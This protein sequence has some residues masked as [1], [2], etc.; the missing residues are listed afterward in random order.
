MKDFK[1]VKPYP[2]IIIKENVKFIPGE[3]Y[4]K[5]KDGIVIG[6]DNIT[7]DGNGAIFR[8]SSTKL[9]TKTETN[10]NDFGYNSLSDKRPEEDNLGFY[11]VGVK[12]EGFSNIF[13][14]NLRIMGFDIGLHVTKGIKWL[15]E[16]NDLSD[17]F[18][19]PEWGWDDHGFH[20]GILLEYVQDSIIRNNKSTNV[21]DA[22]N[23]R[24]SN[25]NTVKNNDFSHVTDVCLK[26]WNSSKNSITENDLSYGIRIKPDEVHAR[27]SSG[28]LI[29]SGSNDNIFKKND[30]T[31][32][33]DGLFIRVLNG[34][35]ST[36]NYFE[37]ND[38]S[39]ANNNAIE[40]WS[41][42]NSYVR[43]KANYSSY[44]F[45][46]GGSDNTL[47][48]ENEAAYNGTVFHNAPE[49]FG[50]AGIAIV[51]GSGSHTKIIGNY[52]HDNNGAGIAIRYNPDYP[53]YHFV[54]QKNKI[55]GNKNKNN[56]KGHGLY[57]KN[58][59]WIDIA[60]N[61]IKN[62]EGKDIFL[63]DNTS[64]IFV[65]QANME[66]KIPYAAFTVNNKSIEVTDDVIF[67]GNASKTSNNTLEYRWDLGDGTITDDNIVKHKYRKPGFYRMGLTVNDGRMAD[68]AFKNI[69]VNYKG[70]E[71]GT[72]DLI[73]KW[74][75]DSDDDEAVLKEDTENYISGNHSICLMT[76][77]GTNH[78]LF[79]PA[80][81]N[82]GL[83]LTDKDIMAFYIKF[84]ADSETDWQKVNKKPVIRLHTTENDYFEYMPEDAYLEQI[85]SRLWEEKY[86]WKY[87]EILLKNPYGWKCKEFGK[88]KVNNINY[89]E[90]E[91]G[92]FKDSKS[93]FWIDGLKF[94]KNE[95]EVYY[96]VNIAENK[97]HIEYPKPIYS[98]TDSNSDAFA[99]LSGNLR[100][101]GN[102]TK[103]WYPDIEGDSFW[104]GVDFGI[105]RE[106]NRLDVY[107]YNNPSELFNGT[108]YLT[109]DNF[110]VEYWD[111]NGL[112][113]IIAEEQKN[114]YPNF[115]SVLFKKVLSSKIRILIDKK[116]NYIPSIYAF[117]V[118]NT[119]NLALELKCNGSLKTKITS[120]MAN[121]L[122]IKK[123]GIILNKEHN[124]TGTEL[125]NLC[126]KLYETENGMPKGLALYETEVPCDMVIPGKETL[127]NFPYPGL[128]PYKRYAIA[129]TQKQIAASRTEGDYYRWPAADTQ[130]GEH[131]GV[132]NASGSKDE[133]DVWGTAWLKIYTN[134]MT[135]DYSHTNEGLG[136]RLGL[137]EQE[138]R[139]QTFTP[140]DAVLCITDGSAY[141]N[142]WMPSAKYENYI[143]M[144]FCEK[145]KIESI[146]LYYLSDSPINVES[147][148]KL[149]SL[150][151]G[152]WEEVK[153]SF[154][155][156]TEGFLRLNAGL[157]CT[158]ALR[159]KLI[160]DKVKY[161][162][163]I[164][165]NRV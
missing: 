113:Y 71:T 43:N 97:E 44:G 32:G 135:L 111:D 75:Y 68:I 24:Y 83:D 53:S 56:Y 48:L 115:N 94:I 84:Q 52:I 23:L 35:M 146:N 138:C 13:V 165:V 100:F 119:N 137:F 96:G 79:Y 102:G 42:G 147:C 28:V 36:G 141:I 5:G 143:E 67:D 127:V 89:I 121:C 161:I 163:E 120:S 133:T 144:D 17:N 118:Y 93:E 20:G 155:L 18:S 73:S 92:P 46:L 145:I 136:N 114:V 16:G 98:S 149:E 3:Y 158:K 7:I 87:F 74:G 51:N 160:N 159:I 49:S 139:W 76:K 60:G 58:A 106:F 12:S 104:Y 103:R 78:K 153:C 107:F 29:E 150:N 148:I 130:N 151:R 99:P 21:W 22:L 112:K 131:F 66:G 64:D 50:N 47:L 10:M 54:I 70:K 57:I 69:Y 95:D 124:E 116:D 86:D 11:G 80:D 31:H 77:K 82:A 72:E 85:F 39:Y 6:A 8:G 41:Y 63:D 4:F 152:K 81:K 59:Q 123:I 9:S 65:R 37:E 128:T 30:I 15:I 62:N 142:G 2:G 125:S 40:A 129:L 19:D 154:N 90:I 140:K 126:V 25:N 33:G 108:K 1:I 101:Y 157:I 122:D 109:P 164:E 162:N 27:D 134:K 34:W 105:K 132:L 117:N 55:E 110:K 91:E 61:E 88:P 38:C 45:W 14:K 156:I 26:L